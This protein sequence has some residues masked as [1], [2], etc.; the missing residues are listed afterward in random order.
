MIAHAKL[1]KGLLKQQTPEFVAVGLGE[2]WF[3]ARPVKGKLIID[4]DDHIGLFHGIKETDFICPAAS[5][6]RRI[7]NER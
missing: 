4:R 1:G 6:A 2:K 5:A 3:A 7:M